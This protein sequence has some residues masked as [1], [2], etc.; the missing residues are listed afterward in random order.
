MR[1]QPLAVEKSVEQWRTPSHCAS[2]NVSLA[3]AVTDNWHRRE[4]KQVEASCQVASAARD[5]QRLRRPTDRD[6]SRDTHRK[7][8]PKATRNTCTGPKPRHRIL[9]TNLALLPSKLQRNRAPRKQRRRN[10]C[11]G[12]RRPA[13]PEPGRGEDDKGE[14]EGE[15][16]SRRGREASLT[17]INPHPARPQLALN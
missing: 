10:T 14:P 7:R 17:L 5:S 4:G 13:A 12:K 2:P 15:Q 8:R 16:V 1:D 11:D 6:S 9:V 3:C